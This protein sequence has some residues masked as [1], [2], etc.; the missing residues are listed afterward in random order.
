MNIQL[1]ISKDPDIDKLILLE[2]ENENETL[3]NVEINTHIQKS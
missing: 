3:S 1:Y 2:L